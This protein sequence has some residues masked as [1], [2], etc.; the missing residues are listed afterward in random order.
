VLRILY[1]KADTPQ[2]L[3]SIK[4]LFLIPQAAEKSLRD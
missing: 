1:K 3:E 4:P 2:V